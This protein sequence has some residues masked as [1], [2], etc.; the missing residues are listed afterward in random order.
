M[1]E[2]RVTS[3]TFQ[4]CDFIKANFQIF[5]NNSESE[6]GTCS[7]VKNNIEVKNVKIIPGGRIIAFDIDGTT[8]FN[9]YLPSGTAA[10][11]EREEMVGS[12]LSNMMLDAGRTGIAMGDFNCLDNPLDATHSAEQKIS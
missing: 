5:A 12:L 8:L 2:C 7:L 6:Y 3:E 4:K 11:A 9:I 10:K 1:Q